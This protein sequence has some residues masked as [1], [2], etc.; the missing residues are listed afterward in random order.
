MKFEIKLPNNTDPV[1]LIGC[2]TFGVFDVYIKPK[3]LSNRSYA[4]FTISRSNQRLSIGQICRLNS[5]K[6]IFNSQIDMK[7]IESYPPEIFYKPPPQ[8]GDNKPITY[9]VNVISGDEISEVHEK[10]CKKFYFF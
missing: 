1:S 2:P 7:W 10:T 9:I 8:N 4:R 3:H 5:S 6:G